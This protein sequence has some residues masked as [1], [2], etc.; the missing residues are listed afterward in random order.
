[1]VVDEKRSL[2]HDYGS[3]G[4]EATCDNCIAVSVNAEV[5]IKLQF[6]QCCQLTI[7]YLTSPHMDAVACRG[8]RSCRTV[9]L[10]G[11]FLLRI[12][13]SNISLGQRLRSARKWTTMPLIIIVSGQKICCSSE[14]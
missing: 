10:E 2:F 3:R 12:L 4:A 14:R 11:S 5:F 6:A 13:C 7:C 1:M 9:K 8:P